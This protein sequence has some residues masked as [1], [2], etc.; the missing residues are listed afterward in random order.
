MCLQSYFCVTKKVNP[1]HLIAPYMHIGYLLDK[2]I[3]VFL[4]I[5]TMYYTTTSNRGKHRKI[6][7][8]RRNIHLETA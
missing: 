3:L 4:Y 8:L 1:I 2:P 6:K 7:K 5:N